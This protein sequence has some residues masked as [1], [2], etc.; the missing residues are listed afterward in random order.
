MLNAHFLDT[1]KLIFISCL[2][3][4]FLHTCSSYVMSYT[5]SLHPGYVRSTLGGDETETGYLHALVYRLPLKT[6]K[7]FK[8]IYVISSYKNDLL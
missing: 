7:M 8:H 1:Y 2:I 3:L 4:V 5:L 6:N